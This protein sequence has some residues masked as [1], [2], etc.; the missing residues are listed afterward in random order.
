MK[1]N[2]ILIAP[3]AAGKGSE[4]GLLKSEYNLAHI[5]TGDL[6]R[7]ESKT[8]PQLKAQMEAGDLIS[9]DIVTRLLEK[10]LKSNECDNGY[11]L[12]G[13][14]RNL[15]QANI[16]EELLNKLDKQINYV[17][18]LDID[19][20]LAL[21]RACGRL[22]C[23]KCGRIYS[24]FSSEFKPKVDNLCDD[25][26]IPLE[27]R[28]DDNEESFKH[29]FDTFMEK[30]QPLIDYYKAKNLLYNVDSSLKKELVHKQVVDVLNQKG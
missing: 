7:E 18:Y 4:A 10:K 11:I 15:N 28:D 8:N 27:H 21:K 17:F 19:K 13:Y 2:I 25:C 1:K 5:S 16:L 29:R 20:D 24:N 12:D 3:P 30:T 14:P 23:P 6:L 26:K 9:D 22:G